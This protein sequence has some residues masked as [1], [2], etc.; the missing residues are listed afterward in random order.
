MSA[1][2][3]IAATAAAWVMRHDRG[4]S[5]AEQ[6]DYLHWL[7]ADP[8][9]AEALTKQRCAWD[10]LDRLAGLPA[11]VPAVPDPDLLTPPVIERRG[12]PR[13]G[14][15]TWAVPALVA[16]AAIAVVVF[17]PAANAPAAARPPVVDLARLAPIEERMLPDGSVVRLNRGA[18]IVVEFSAGER[19]VELRRGEAAFEV[20]KDFARPFVVQSAG[21]TVRA[22]GTAFNVRLG[23]VAVDVI[24]T[25][26]RVIVAGEGVMPLA[27]MPHSVAAGQ[28][29]VVPLERG[30][31]PPP[32]DTLAA[33]ELARRLAWQPRLLTF[34]DEPLTVILNEFNRHNPVALRTDAQ[35]LQALRLTARFR[36]D[37][38]P[39]FLRLLESDFQVRAEYRA[40]G[41]I[42][43]H[44]LR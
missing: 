6:D 22:L 26:G 5:P 21:I 27:V 18:E 9:H 2:E 7:A 19:R 35:A 44:P 31:P 4:L 12:M 10:A 32:V 28:R 11:A 3:T 40:N 42:A 13:R 8:R 20:A 33:E 14:F 17:W 38:V 16:A 39:G 41:E 37:N 23:D 1:P 43:L 15:R 25:E 36:S 24:V 29:V 30:V 34:S